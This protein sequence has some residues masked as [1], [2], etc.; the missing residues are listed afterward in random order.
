MTNT[1]GSATSNAAA[2]IL[3][4]G[5]AITGQPADQAVC[6]SG[7]ASFSVTASGSPA[8]TYQWRKGTTNLTDGGNISGATMATLTINPAGTGD[9]ATDYNCV[10]TNTC[11]SATS[12]NAV[13]TVG[14]GPAITAPPASQALVIGG[15]AVFSVTAN[16]STGLTYQWRKDMAP[17][18]DGGTISGATTA[19][20]TISPVAATDAGWYDV[21]VTDD[22]GSATSDAAAFWRRGDMNCDGVINYGDINPFVIALNG[23]AGYEALYPDCS[24][25]NAD[26]DNNGV[27]NYGDIN[28]F[29]AL[30][31]T[32]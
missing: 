1:C 16:S 30:L 5:P 27:V 29:V 18:T 11:G 6:S 19:T 20:L 17:L 13:L 4:A 25:L 28:P 3:N 12:N 14:T 24:Y 8:P 10:V 26:T 7:S 23:Q 22:C 32:K 21:V 15:T 2:L 31:A 9:A